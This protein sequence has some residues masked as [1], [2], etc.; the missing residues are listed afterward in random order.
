[1]LDSIT[2][3]KGF[4]RTAYFGSSPGGAPDKNE[5][6]VFFLSAGPQQSKQ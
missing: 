2:L 4:V 1:M 6:H 3:D 5:K